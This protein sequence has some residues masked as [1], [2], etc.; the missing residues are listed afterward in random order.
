MSGWARRVSTILRVAGS[1]RKEGR[2]L[3]LARVALD[4]RHDDQRLLEVRP[5]AC[6]LLLPEDNERRGLRWVGARA[7]ALCHGVG[8]GYGRGS[9]CLAPTRA[10]QTVRR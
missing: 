7:Y 1:A 8:D 3:V 6:R 10:V 9:R 4:L 2:T 5:R